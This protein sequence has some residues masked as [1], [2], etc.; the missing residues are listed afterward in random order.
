[1][2]SRHKDV[3]DKLFEEIVNVFGTDKNAK[4]THHQLQELKYME[5]VIK[6]TL[7]LYPSL[8]AIGRYL[9][10]DLKL[11]DGRIIPAD[12]NIILNLHVTFKDP[13]YFKDPLR[14]DPDRFSLDNLANEKINPFVFIPFSAGPRNCI[15]QK[16]AML[17]IKT[18]VSKV[19]RNFELV[20][21][22]EEPIISF[23]LVSRSINGYQMGLN[24]REY[25]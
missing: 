5:M 3:Q 13:K 16:Y 8:H 9:D 14:F 4:V 12:T 19:L 2:L 20:P 22:C 21:R 24:T 1:M 25:V 6:E 18:I 10:Q 23:E 17:D 7:R 15:G 11:D